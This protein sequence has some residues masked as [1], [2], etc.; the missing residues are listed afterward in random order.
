L[1]PF[2]GTFEDVQVE[3]GVGVGAS[4]LCENPPLRD[5][6]SHLWV[7]IGFFF[8]FLLFLLLCSIVLFVS[9][10]ASASICSLSLSHYVYLSIFS[11]RLPSSVSAK[12]QRH[13]QS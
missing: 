3:V 4:S 12:R 9:A 10:P 11:A 7:S 6:L 8:F 13:V 1:L 5:P 2:I